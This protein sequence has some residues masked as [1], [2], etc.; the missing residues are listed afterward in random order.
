MKKQLQGKVV[1]VKMA[2]TVVVAVSSKKPHPM[3]KKLIKHTKRIAADTGS[4]SL[5]L[6]DEVIIEEVRPL[7]KTKFFKVVEVPSE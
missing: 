6:G 3:Y 7:S 1:S 4:L 2:K 5:A